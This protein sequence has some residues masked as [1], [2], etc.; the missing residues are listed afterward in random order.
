VGGQRDRETERQRDKETERQGDRETRSRNEG[1]HTSV[2]GEGL[3]AGCWRQT[4]P[5]GV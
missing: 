4:I 2:D 5:E 3:I 1:F